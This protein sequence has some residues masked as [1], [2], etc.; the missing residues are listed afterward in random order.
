MQWNQVNGIYKQDYRQKQFVPDEPFVTFPNTMNTTSDDCV[1]L[2]LE[3]KNL[4][5]MIDRVDSDDCTTLVGH[6]N[7][8]RRYICNR[9]VTKAKV[10]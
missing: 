3:P 5:R 6:K 9:C 7:S 8:Q 1:F 10:R 2:P 4:Y